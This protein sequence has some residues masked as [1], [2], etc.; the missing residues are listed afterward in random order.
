MGR[1]LR[2]PVLISW[3]AQALGRPF[4]GPDRSIARVDSV[5]AAGDLS[6]CFA[7]NATWASRAHKAAAVLCEQRDAEAAPDR[8]IISP[9][10]RL[11]FAR[12]LALLDSEVG[13]LWSDADPII[14]PTARIGQHAVIGKGVRIGA[15]SVI[16]HH[17]VI[18]D[19]VEIGDSCNIKSGAVI[20]EEGFGFERGDDG[21]AVRLPHIGIVKIGNDVE[22]GSLT[23]VCRGTLDDTEIHDGAKIDDHVHIA[24]NITV[25]EHAFVIACAEVSGGV[26]IG[27]RAWIA[28]AATVLNQISIGD[29]AVVGLGAV[30]VRN[31]EAKTTV[32]GNPA[33]PLKNRH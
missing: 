15:N 5:G 4:T 25:G 28:P 6:F 9:N 8:S 13:F 18:G 19:E 7:K 11:D 30:V 17:V 10:P 12:S 20:G 24:H 27:K 22:I 23:T 26:R 16:G 33:K 1:A 2:H 29:D 3:I 32:V 21:A 31:V 14:H